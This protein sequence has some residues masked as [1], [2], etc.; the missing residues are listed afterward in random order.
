MSWIYNQSTGILYDPS[1]TILARGYAGGNCGKNPEG[2]NN[3]DMQY[4]KCIG[5]IPIGKYTFGTP[6]EQSHLGPF[7]IPLIP[8]P[9][10]EMH[11]RSG[12][13]MHGDRSNATRSASEGCIIMPRNIRE[14]CWHSEIH[15][16]E[17]VRG[18]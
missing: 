4:E 11:G 18:D 13:F 8:D 3:P 7:A 17:V 6:I 16:L 9:S 1:G 12:F 10:N 5:P 15:Q 2:I 14:V